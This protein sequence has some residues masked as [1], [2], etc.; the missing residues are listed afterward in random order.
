MG[1]GSDRLMCRQ[2]FGVWHTLWQFVF[3][4]K[5]RRGKSKRDSDD[6]S[7]EPSLDESLVWPVHETD[8]NA[9]DDVEVTKAWSALSHSKG[10]LMH[11]FKFDLCVDTA[12][13]SGG[14][15]HGS[16]LHMEVNFSSISLATTFGLSCKHGSKCVGAFFRNWSLGTW[17]VMLSW[18][19]CW[20]VLL[21]C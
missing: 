2:V 9:M 16:N 10:N 12:H 18:R 11:R 6:A 19:F 15:W 14:N 7:C 17:N 13:Y 4:S 3:A 5:R 8:S 21:P 20:C 1:R